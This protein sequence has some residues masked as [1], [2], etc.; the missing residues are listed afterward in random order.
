MVSGRRASRQRPQRDDPED[1]PD[2]REREAV[3]E[4]GCVLQVDVVVARAAVTPAVSVR[5]GERISLE[6]ERE[7]H[8]WASAKSALAK[9]SMRDT[10]ALAY[11][12]KLSSWVGRAM[13]RSV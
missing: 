6:R 2:M 10:L 4:V 3:E 11:P 8:P 13:Y 12:A 5:G 1:A 9:P 7:S